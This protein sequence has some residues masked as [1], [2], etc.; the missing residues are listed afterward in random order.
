M[1]SLFLFRAFVSVRLSSWDRTS[2]LAAL[3]ELMLD[4]FY[5]TLEGFGILIEKEWLSFG[6]RFAERYGHAS[7]EHDDT[8]RAPIFIQF[9]DCV[10]QLLHQFPASFEFNEDFL[11]AIHDHVTSHRF[12]TFLFNCVEERE[13]YDIRK[14]TVSLWTFLLH[15]AIRTKFYNPR[16]VHPPHVARWNVKDVTAASAHATER[17]DQARKQQQSTSSRPMSP[18]PHLPTVP[19]LTGTPSAGVIAS[20]FCIPSVSAK[21]LVLWEKM[22]LRYEREYMR[23][24]SQAQQQVAQRVTQALAARA[25]KP[26]APPPPPTTPSPASAAAAAAADIDSAWMARYNMLVSR[27]LDAGIDIDKLE[28]GIFVS[29]TGAAAPPVPTG[30]PPPPP[31]RKASPPAVV[32]TASPLTINPSSSPRRA[33][34]PSPAPVSPNH[35]AVSLHLPTASGSSK[36]SSLV[37]TSQLVSLKA[38]IDHTMLSAARSQLRS[39]G[40][41]PP[42]S[43]LP[44]MPRRPPPTVPPQQHHG[45]DADNGSGAAH[46]RT[47]STPI[48]NLHAPQMHTQPHSAD[49]SDSDSD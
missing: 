35:S 14:R 8:Q 49:I 1:R 42:L 38:S 12:G 24:Q 39:N 3:T 41:A 25:M 29:K 19:P 32:G 13:R 17:V 4:P 20:F 40:T 23:T 28:A 16:Y 21:R 33:S 37:S 44:T 10:Y 47:T 27:I 7:S 45:E 31:V 48:H 2:Q 36:R 22:H 46:S 5:R 43:P 15:G 26:V 9:L 11:L 34:P 6:H 18:P 30:P